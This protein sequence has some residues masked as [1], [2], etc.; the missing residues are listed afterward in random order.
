MCQPRPVACLY[1]QAYCRSSGSSRPAGSRA[2]FVKVEERE[3]D[4]FVDVHLRAGR[5]EVRTQGFYAWD[6]GQ[7][8]L[9]TDHVS[10]DTS[11]RVWS[12]D[13]QGYPSC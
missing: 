8:G 1:G 4:V 12:L 6:S 13:I 9:E 11:M 3:T 7:I 10:N 2:F 5:H